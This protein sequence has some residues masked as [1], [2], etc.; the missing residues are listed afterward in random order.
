[1]EGLRDIFNKLETDKEAFCRN[2]QR[3]IC[4]I[5]SYLYDIIKY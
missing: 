4:V 2:C 5:I 3:L 1:M